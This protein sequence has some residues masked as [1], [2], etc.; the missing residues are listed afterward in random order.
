[1]PIRRLEGQEP[2]IPRGSPE[3]IETR[4]PSPTSITDKAAEV[5]SAVWNKMPKVERKKTPEGETSRYNAMQDETA[6][7]EAKKTNELAISQIHLEP[8]SIE[9][10]LE[11]IRLKNKRAELEQPLLK[12]EIEPSGFSKKREIG[13]MT[14]MTIE[15]G[16]TGVN[17][18][19]GVYTPPN[20]PPPKK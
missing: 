12:G 7:P 5:A 16:R 8:K 4:A 10:D 13:A 2:L 9:V 17:Y 19:P 18:N 3:S 11:E 20:I 6:H 1:M 14:R 15:A